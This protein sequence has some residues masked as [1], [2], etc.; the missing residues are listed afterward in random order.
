MDYPDSFELT[1]T[2]EM[3]DEST[4]LILEA[5]RKNPYYESGIPG[6][7]GTGCVDPDLLCTNCALGY[8]ANQFFPDAHCEMIDCLYVGEA[9]YNCAGLSDIVSAFDG[10]FQDGKFTPADID[11]PRT[12]NLTKVAY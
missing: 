7:D 2:R 1:L 6:T 10:Q 9:E 4:R 3:W 12:I 11:L 5:A 8:A